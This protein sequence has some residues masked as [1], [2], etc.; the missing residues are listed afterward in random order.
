MTLTF[1]NR[2][3]SKNFNVL[4]TFQIQGDN[5]LLP[6]DVTTDLSRA[7][8]LHMALNISGLLTLLEEKSYV[9]AAGRLPMQ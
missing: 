7:D 9:S 5:H 6:V 3:P 2:G 8:V 4:I 1:W